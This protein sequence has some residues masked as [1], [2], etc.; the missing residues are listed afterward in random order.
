MVVDTSVLLAVVF[1]EEHAT[2]AVEQLEQHAA[3][4]RM[5]TVNLAETLIL[6]RD[7]Q[8]QLYGELEIQLLQLGI[9]FVP[10]DVVQARHAAEARLRYP[11]NLGD[12][13]AYALARAEDCAILT[14]DED[15]RAVDRDVLLP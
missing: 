1:D 2:W 6:I 13:F 7:R 5:S 4:L 12:C 9:R 11:L 3:E 14:L 8:P 15:F 10:P